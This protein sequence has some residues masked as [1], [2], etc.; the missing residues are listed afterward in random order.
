MEIQIKELELIVTPRPAVISE[1]KKNEMVSKLDEA[2]DAKAIF[3]EGG[4]EGQK[5]QEMF[6]LMLVMGIDLEK[7]RSDPS[8]QERLQKVM[9]NF[10][11]TKPITEEDHVHID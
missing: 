7:V 8:I 2:I 1:D 5:S 6:K 4:D 3:S 9:E 10:D 11:P